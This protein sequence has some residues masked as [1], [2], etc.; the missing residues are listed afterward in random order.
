MVGLPAADPLRALLARLADRIDID[1]VDPRALRNQDR[2]SAARAAI[3]ETFLAMQNDGSINVGVDM[4]DIAHVALHEAVGLGALDDL[5]SEETVQ[6]IVVH[7]PE[8]IF[9]DRGEGLKAVSA[10]FSS[11][12][13]LVRVARRLAGQTGQAFQSQPFVRGR[14]EFGPRLTILQSPL[15]AS[16]PVIDLRMGRDITLGGLCEAGCISQDAATYLAAAVAERRNVM[17]VGPGGSGVADV[18]SALARELPDDTYAVAVEATPD[19]D[20]DRNRIICLNAADSGV[21]L[22]EAVA[23]GARLAPEHLLICGLTGA[24]A[25]AALSAILGREGGNLLGVHGWSRDD[26]IESVLL[27]ASSNGAPRAVVAALLAK[28]VDLLVATLQSPAGP[29]VEAMLELRGCEAG[30]IS[31]E[32]VRL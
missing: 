19:L 3:A 31:Y 9:V 10:R 22:A 24:N 32:S 15:V 11:R 20:I 18:M 23:Q 12:G 1:N 26:A 16:G 8:R 25:T 5:L 17:I 27:A 30:E 2:W 13:A 4:R 14:L 28:S 6:A 29:R 21:S 7:G